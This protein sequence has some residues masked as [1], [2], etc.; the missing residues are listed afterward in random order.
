VGVF[1]PSYSTV[2]P[3]VPPRPIRTDSAEKSVAF[4]IA[5][6]ASMI[7]GIELVRQGRQIEANN[8]DITARKQALKLHY[9]KIIG[10]LKWIWTH[11]EATLGAPIFKIS[12]RLLGVAS[13]L[14]AIRAILGKPLWS[15]KN[16]NP[17]LKPYLIG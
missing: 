10:F 5:S 13:F 7:G 6:A 11:P 9:G 4:G 16:Q 2:Q 1:L 8:L 14:F 17:Y 15:N 12:G 3:G